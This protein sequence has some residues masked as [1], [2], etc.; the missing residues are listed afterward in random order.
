MPNRRNPVIRAATIL[1]KGGPHVKNTSAKRQQI[2]QQLDDEIFECLEERRTT[3][4]S[5][6]RKQS[7]NPGTSKGTNKDRPPRRYPALCQ[8]HP[9][10]CLMGLSI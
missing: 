1:R 9:A 7:S 5:I 3:R 2:R 6:V 4:S 8:I 10:P